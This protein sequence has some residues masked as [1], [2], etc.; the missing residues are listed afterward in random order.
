MPNISNDTARANYSNTQRPS[1]QT[2]TPSS[3][4]TPSTQAAPA[5]GASIAGTGSVADTTRTGRAKSRHA[6]M[7]IRAAA[8]NAASLEPTPQVRHLSFGETVQQWVASGP[9]EESASRRKAA[10][11]LNDL[12]HYESNT[13]MECM[14]PGT[15]SLGELNLSSLPPVFH[16][17]ISVTVLNLRCNK[18]TTLPALPPRLDHLDLSAN[19]LISLPELPQTLTVLGADFNRLA[20]LPEL[21]LNLLYLSVSCNRLLWLPPIPPKMLE[22]QCGNNRLEHLPVLPNSLTMLTVSHNKLK[23]LQPLTGHFA[24]LD[25][26]HNEI[27][28]LPAGI[29]TAVSGGILDIAHN[30]LHHSTLVQLADASPTT[31]VNTTGGVRFNTVPQVEQETYVARPSTRAW[32]TDGLLNRNSVKSLVKKWTGNSPPGEKDGRRTAGYFILEAH[33][34]KSGSLDISNLGLTS[35]PPCL[36]NLS[37]L[38]ILQVNGNKLQSLPQLPPNIGALKINSNKLT[39]LPA[40]PNSLLSLEADQN[41]LRHLPTLPD[42][43]QEL[44]VAQN[45]LTTISKLP[46]A[47]EDI[48]LTGNYLRRLPPLPR[49]L[50]QLAIN[51]N[52][53]E[54]LP[55]LPPRLQSMH[56]QCNQL[57]RLPRVPEPMYELIV[58]GNQL[59]ELPKILF[60]P[61]IKVGVFLAADNPLPEKELAR[62]R[63]LPE[64]IVT[65]ITSPTPVANPFNAGAADKLPHAHIV[66]DAQ[67]MT[68]ALQ[69]WHP[70]TKNTHARE[71]LWGAIA[72]EDYALTFAGFLDRL[73]GT[74]EY[75]SPAYRPVL[76]ARVEGLLEAMAKDPALRKLCF[77]ISESASTSCGD[78]VALAL[79]DMELARIDHDAECG[80]NSLEDLHATGMEMYRLSEVEKIADEK[81]AAL[82]LN[83]FTPDAIEVRLG[84][85]IKLTESLQL[86][87]VS[88]AMIFTFS[89]EIYDSDLASAIKRVNE[90]SKSEAPLQFMANWH[91]W[92]KAVERGCPEKFLKLAQERKKREEALDPQ[93]AHMS[94]QEWITAF[95]DNERL[96][97]KERVDLVVHLTKNYYRRIGQA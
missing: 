94:E 89:T 19:R 70:P 85:H 58:S 67:T 1:S 21:P 22:I 73:E 76:R 90:R 35:L 83:N 31:I 2:T 56:A 15:I 13:R 8:R 75:E 57:K 80:A 9:V 36:K 43:L 10:T 14:K 26:R 23:T 66:G 11:I 4:V 93:P 20:S 86:P 40:L 52:F 65:A 78:R 18:L 84:F 37:S 71:A 61:R 34:S 38:L 68:S 81:V 92:Q 47:L 3:A 39:E 72:Q 97:V 16:L 60:S 44:W 62:L 64:S 96:A 95:R 69:K 82:R 91:P 50:K 51:Y 41:H 28:H 46:S 27:E 25:L 48:R 53:I 45:Y 5:H 30:P 87:L 24:M 88:D 79:D 74:A 55:D 54:E 32:I 49:N 7:E 59:V 12:H 29:A 17:L 63:A 77:T 42:G 33:K 6:L